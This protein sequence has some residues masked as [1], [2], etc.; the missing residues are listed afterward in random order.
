MPSSPPVT[1]NRP[2][3]GPGSSLV[4]ISD[5]QG[6]L[7]EAGYNTQR[8]GGPGNVISSKSQ[9]EQAKDRRGTFGGGGQV[10]SG[11]GKHSTFY[12]GKRE[13]YTCFL[14]PQGRLCVCGGGGDYLGRVYVEGGG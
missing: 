1:P 7:Y 3:R 5:D 13:C 2:T 8:T 11:G 10:S 14:I 4:S 6:T 12:W 9:D